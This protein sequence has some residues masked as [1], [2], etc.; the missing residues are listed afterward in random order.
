MSRSVKTKPFHE[1]QLWF[2]QRNMKD[3]MRLFS[4][5]VLNRLLCSSRLW[6]RQNTDRNLMQLM[7]SD[8]ETSDSTRLL[9][10][11]SVLDTSPSLMDLNHIIRKLN[12]C[13]HVFRVG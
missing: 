10:Y 3:H 2:V 8:A 4:L 7:T 6:S 9:C 13:H 11:T 5:K 12:L 1:H